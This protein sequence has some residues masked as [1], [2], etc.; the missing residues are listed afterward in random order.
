MLLVLQCQLCRSGCLYNHSGHL[1]YPSI[2]EFSSPDQRSW[3]LSLLAENQERAGQDGLSDDTYQRSL[4]QQ[5]DLYTAIAY[6]DL[7]LRN[8]KPARAIRVLADY[9]AT[10]AVL[11]RRAFSLR[12]LGDSGWL[13]YRTELRQRIAD[14]K[15]RGD[16]IELHGR[17]LALGALW[18]DDDPQAALVL[19]KR[20]LKLQREPVDWL[21][22]RT[23]ALAGNDSK[24]LTEFDAEIKKSG[25]VDARLARSQALKRSIALPGV[26]S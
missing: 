26:G 2:L 22:A 12:R 7:L 8:D 24:A 15:R 9:P 5:N 17:E 3:L 23:A 10:D 13:T 16:D 11:L 18:L 1:H 25:L 19:A 21:V 6:A 20:N 4:A 14:L